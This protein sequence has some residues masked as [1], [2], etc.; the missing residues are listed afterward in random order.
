M[1]TLRARPVI[2]HTT[3]YPGCHSPHTYVS[4]T[5]GKLKSVIMC[6]N[7]SCV[8]VCLF[9]AVSENGREKQCSLSPIQPPPPLLL[10][11]FFQRLGALHVRSLLKMWSGE[12]P[13]VVSEV[14]YCIHNCN[15]SRLNP[16]F[17]P[18]KAL[19]VA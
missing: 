18:V 2:L 5:E 15:T 4:H 9:L 16:I 8:C 11:L 6:G 19:Q 17:Y 1:N 14:N 3:I 10:S 12:P 7:Q 13:L